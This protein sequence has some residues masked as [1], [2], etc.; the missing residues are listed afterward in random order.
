VAGSCQ[1]LLV[2]RRLTNEGG[3]LVV[4][5]RIQVR[6]NDGVPFRDMGRGLIGMSDDT[7]GG[8]TWLLGEGMPKLL[9]REWIMFSTDSR[10]CIRVLVGDRDMPLPRRLS[11]VE[12][13]LSGTSAQ[14]AKGGGR[15]P[16]NSGCLNS[17]GEYDGVGRR[18]PPNVDEF[19]APG[20]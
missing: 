5:Q 15:P 2:I 7:N 6:S 4:L 17:S 16:W 9:W 3:S 1:Q 20:V 14:G 19:G 11:C 12:A 8:G 18:F 10:D 13:G